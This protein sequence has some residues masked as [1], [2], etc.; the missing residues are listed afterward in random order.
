MSFQVNTPPILTQCQPYSITWTG[1]VAPFYLTITKGGD[2]TSVIE[3]FGKQNSEHYPWI[4]DQPIETSV[5]FMVTDSQGK[6]TMS[7]AS[8][9]ITKGNSDDCM[10]GKDSN[11]SPAANSTTSSPDDHSGTPT[12]TST[13]TSA[14]AKPTGT[15]SEPS[16]AASTP[17]SPSTPQDIDPEPAARPTPQPP[18]SSARP[19]TKSV[20]SVALMLLLGIAGL[21][22][23]TS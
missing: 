7:A 2:I 20:R 6:S 12:S 16:G 23:L 21:L 9:P 5:T 3:N 8:P 1:G 15:I 22:A 10:K 13:N 19:L 17:T 18:V 11:T 4:V 14:S